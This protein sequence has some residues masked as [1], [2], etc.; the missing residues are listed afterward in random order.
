MKLRWRAAALPIVAAVVVL[1][2]GVG[3]W[4][5]VAQD[6]AEQLGTIGGSFTLTDGDGR[7]ITERDLRGHYLL[8]Y[9]GYTYCPDVCPTTLNEIAAALDKLGPRADAVQPVFITV[10]P[11]RDTPAVMKTYAAAFGPRMLGLTGTPEQIAAVAREYRVY[12]AIHRDADAK[13]DAYTVD[14]S[15]IVYLMDRDGRFVAPIRADAAAEQMAADI[16]SHLPGG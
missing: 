14:H 9:F 8:V 4:H 1:L 7:T 10:D 15:S 12:Y 6:A 3:A 2:I 13:S 11:Q 16:G 5:F